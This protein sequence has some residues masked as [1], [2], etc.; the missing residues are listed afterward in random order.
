MSKVK[1]ETLLLTLPDSE[2]RSG[3]PRGECLLLVQSGNSFERERMT[4]FG[5]SG[6]DDR[7]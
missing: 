1:I 6:H 7:S 3:I 4:A 2:F 5:K